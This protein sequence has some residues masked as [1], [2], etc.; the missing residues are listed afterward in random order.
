MQA[1]PNRSVSVVRTDATWVTR[2]LADMVIESTRA[3]TAQEDAE[4]AMRAVEK[5]R[6]EARKELADSE[7]GVAAWKWVALEWKALAMARG[8]FALDSEPRRQIEAAMQ[9][10]DCLRR[11]TFVVGAGEEQEK[12]DASGGDGPVAVHGESRSTFHGHNACKGAEA[13]APSVTHGPLGEQAAV[14]SGPASPASARAGQDGTDL[15]DYELGRLTVGAY[16]LA[17]NRG[18]E[19]KAAC[20]EAGAKA[21]SLL[22]ASADAELAGMRDR[23]I[24]LAR[25]HV[26]AS[27]GEM[28]AFQR[29]QTDAAR[30]IAEDLSIL[31]LRPLAHDAE[32]KGGAT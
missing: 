11:G 21:R 25:R 8:H 10:G 17:D 26:P 18:V 30:C 13:I 22:R 5:E 16:Q 23:A 15:S 3:R 24:D 28:T 19:G 32:T 29:G 31:P 12:G 2:S 1:P 14:A 27:G 4:R 9:A 20:A 6:D 7:K